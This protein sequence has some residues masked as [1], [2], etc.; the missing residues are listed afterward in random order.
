MRNL[1]YCILLLACSSKNEKKSISY[2]VDITDKKIIEMTI[3]NTTGKDYF[4]AHPQLFFIKTRHNSNKNIVTEDVITEI[5]YNYKQIVMDKKND[6]NALIVNSNTNCNSIFFKLKN[7]EHI[8]LKYN[9]SNKKDLST[10]IYS[11]VANDINC[12]I[13]SIEKE[14]ISDYSYYKGILSLPDKIIIK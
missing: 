12:N 13:D 2:D 14:S 4:F 3:S 7:G 6:G 9:I 10:G 8:K 11:V 1:V 5:E